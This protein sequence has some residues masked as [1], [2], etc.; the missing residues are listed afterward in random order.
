M[1]R[2][3]QRDSKSRIRK[4]RNIPGALSRGTPGMFSAEQRRGPDGIAEIPKGSLLK[5]NDM[6]KINKI[7]EIIS[8][9]GII[10]IVFIILMQITMRY[11]FSFPLTWSDELA[12]ILHIWV[13]YL[14]TYI[15][16]TKNEHVKVEYFMSFLP[17]KFEP[18]LQIFI[19]LVCFGFVLS[20]IYS[21]VLVVIKLSGAR[22]A[23]MGLPMPFVFSCTIIGSILML[24][25][26]GLKIVKLFSSNYVD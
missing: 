7:T 20:L 9:A 24:V 22:T 19:N 25:Y 12:R 6:D 16:V 13:V 26:F 14:G 3:Y 5:R 11:V 23:T 15:A 18:T 8:T 4:S 1:E 10:L 21:S 2:I 17:K